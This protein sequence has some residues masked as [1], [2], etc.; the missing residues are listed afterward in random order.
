MHIQQQ[1]QETQ[2]STISY[3]T[4]VQF[5]HQIGIIIGF[6]TSTAS[7]FIDWQLMI[8]PTSK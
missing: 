5:T 7:A 4:A 6:R 3:E 2:A 8:C 1:Q